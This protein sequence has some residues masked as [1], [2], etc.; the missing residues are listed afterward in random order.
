MSD[1][2]ASLIGNLVA[3]FWLTWPLLG[4]MVVGVSLWMAFTITRSLRGIR[5]E[6]ARLNDQIAHGAFEHIGNSVAQA[7]GA[8]LPL[9][10]DVTY[11]R[12]GSLSIR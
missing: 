7:G 4:A 10:S 3:L 11:T 5:R 12:T 8:E 6:L 9:R 1:D 2:A